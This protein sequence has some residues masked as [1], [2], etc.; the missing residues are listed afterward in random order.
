M[1]DTLKELVEKGWQDKGTYAGWQILGLEQQR[2]LYDPNT[3]AVYLR[4]DLNKP[5]LT[6]LEAGHTWD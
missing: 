4:Y 2:L 3:Q 5:A 6:K 1:A